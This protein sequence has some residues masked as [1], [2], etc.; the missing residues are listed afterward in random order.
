MLCFSPEWFFARAYEAIAP[1][2]ERMTR[3]A[4]RIRR[5]ARVIGMLEP[6]SY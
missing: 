6:A 1:D 5:A 2:A 4:E 3:D